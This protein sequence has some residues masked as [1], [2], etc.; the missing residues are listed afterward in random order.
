M[1]WLEKKWYS[2]SKLVWMLWPLSL[3]YR[4]LSH[5]RRQRLKSAWADTECLPLPVII[6]GNLSVG[7]NGK[8]PLVIRLVKLLRQHGYHP[9]VL[10]RGYGGKTHYPASVTKDSQP[11]EVGDEPVL[12][13]QHIQCP[14][15]VDPNRVRGARFLREEFSCD[16]IICDDG[17]QHYRLQRD[18][19]IVVMDGQRRLGNGYL[20]P[21]GPLREGP[22][23]L[24]EVDFVIVNG[25]NTQ[26]R[27]FSMGLESGRLINVKQSTLSQSVN[28]LKEPVTA[29]AAI[30]NPQRFF[31][32]LQSKHIAIKQCIPF[33]DHHLFSAD[34]MP[35][36]TVIMTEKD[37]V[38]CKDFAQ[39]NWWYLPVSATLSA[40]FEQQFLA[41]VKEVKNGIR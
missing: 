34:D 12:M 23:R 39:D 37:A 29:I 4:L 3:L 5:M 15:V 32:L 19:E 33:S 20:L 17:L 30:G 11:T 27:E 13:R 9:G 16:L 35:T 6:V 14:I 38:K 26:K 25:G 2:S 18:I 22:W 10:S 40:E 24:A 7:G 31:K 21:M 36:G 1:T 41:K 8:T 28:D